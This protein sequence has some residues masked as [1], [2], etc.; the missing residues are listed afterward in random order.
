MILTL[1]R[2]TWRTALGA[3]AVVAVLAPDAPLA[4]QSRRAPDV[5]MRDGE[6]RRV[7]LSDFKGKV[8]LVEL[9]ASW[10]PSCKVSFPAIDALYREYRSRGVEIIAVNVDQR[11]RDADT[12]L[13]A[14]PHE[15]LIVFDPRAR[16]L[17]AFGAPGV[18]SSYLIDRQ[19]T[20]RF[21]HEGY[22]ADT[23]VEYR[24]Q[25]DELLAEHAQ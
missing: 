24:R 13:K 7:R 16:V 5:D 4:E 2:S 17:Q 1:S 25:L 19:G 10:C 23:M 12:Y 22:T 11:R 6:G 20:I 8:V 21:T 9:W 15:K 3:M 14:H 18:P